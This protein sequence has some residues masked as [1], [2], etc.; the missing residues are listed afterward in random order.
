MTTHLSLLWVYEESTPVTVQRRCS[1]GWESRKMRDTP[2][3]R[4]I[5]R[6]RDDE[7]RA[8]QEQAA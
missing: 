8:E 1:C 2:E 5:L 3:S 4:R 6:N 7:H